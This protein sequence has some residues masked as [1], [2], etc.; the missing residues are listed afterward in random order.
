MDWSEVGKTIAPMAPTIGGI[1]GGLIPVPFGST[2]GTGIGTAVAAALGVPPTP[3]AVHAA[4]TT[5]APDEVTARLA[6]QEAQV[7]ADVEKYKA[8]LADIQ[9]AR[10]VG[11]AYQKV[12]SQIQWAPAAVS[13]L[14]AIGFFGTLWILLKAG[15]NFNDTV[16]QVLL[17]LVGSLVAYMNQVVNYWLGSSAGSQGKSDQ[18]AAL[19]SGLPTPPVAPKKK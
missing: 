18:L 7:S 4:V 6:V 3:E 13:I 14:V 9:D 19:A 11:L 16:G 5:M 2:I 17:I 12:G 10:Q 15:V 1:L 8:T